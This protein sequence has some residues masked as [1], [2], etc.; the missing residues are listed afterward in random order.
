MDWE[1]TWVSAVYGLDINIDGGKDRK[2]VF[3]EEILGNS[4]NGAAC[5]FDWFGNG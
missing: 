1:S 5:P 3:E 2:G 4:W